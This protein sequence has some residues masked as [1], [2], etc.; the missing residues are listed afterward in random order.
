M[1]TLFYK[2]FVFVYYFRLEF[3]FLTKSYIKYLH[4]FTSLNPTLEP[5]APNYSAQLL[6]LTDIHVLNATIIPCLSAHRL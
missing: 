6:L 3:S 1:C 2:F 5:F 4:L